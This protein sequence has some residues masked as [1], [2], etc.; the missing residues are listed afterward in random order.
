M[1]KKAIRIRQKR[2]NYIMKNRY[3]TDSPDNY[4]TNLNFLES[5]TDEQLDEMSNYKFDDE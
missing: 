4:T 5:L 3:G 2:I 1:S